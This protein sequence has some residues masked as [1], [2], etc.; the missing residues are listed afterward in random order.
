MTSEVKDQRALPDRLRLPLMIDAA[1]LAADLARLASLQW[2]MHF[3]PENFSGRWDVL[4]LRAP[5]GAVHPILRITSTP[6]CDRWEDTEIRGMCPAISALLDRLECPLGAVRLMRLTAGSVINEHSDPDLS[7][8]QGTARLHV[9]IT[10]NPDVDFRINHRRVDMRPGELWYVRLSDPH[11]VSNRG[12]SDRVHLVIDA[13]IN[14]WLSDLL[15]AA[16]DAAK[17]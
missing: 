6:G 3:V 16:T 8:E 12:T 11:S 2:T 15:V 1:L 4:P 17:S 7:A 13:A 9:A 10:T 5:A 14:P